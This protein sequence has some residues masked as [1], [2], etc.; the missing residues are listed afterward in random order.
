M[1]QRTPLPKRKKSQ[2]QFDSAAH[3]PT[4]TRNRTK[5]SSSHAGGSVW[6]KKATARTM[7]ANNTKDLQYWKIDFSDLQL[8]S[9]ICHMP[10]GECFR[11]KFRSADVVARVINLQKTTDLIKY[12]ETESASLFTLRHQN[13]V[14]FLGA[15]LDYSMPLYFVTEALPR[16]NLFDLIHNPSVELDPRKVNKMASSIVQGMLYLHSLVPSILHLSLS[17]MNVM[18]EE[19]YN[20]K[21]GEIGFNRFKN[22]E[23]CAQK[24]SMPSWI[25]PE[26]LLSG[27]ASKQSDVYSFGIIF[28]EM[29]TRQIPYPNLTPAQIISGVTMEGIRPEVPTTCP[30]EYSKVF[31]ACWPHNPTHRQ[32]FSEIAIL[33][34]AIPGDADVKEMFLKSTIINRPASNRGD[35]DGS[36]KQTV[37]TVVEARNIQLADVTA[38]FEPMIIVKHGPHEFKTSVMQESSRPVWNESFECENLDPNERLNIFLT[39]ASKSGANV[40]GECTIPTS[41]FVGVQFLDKWYPLLASNARASR[42]AQVRISIKILNEKADEKEDQEDGISAKNVT[43][44]ERL[45]IGSIGEVC[46]AKWKGQFVAVRKLFAKRLSPA[47]LSAVED[48]IFVY[49]QLYHPNLIHIHGASLK[50]GSIFFV[51][52]L[53]EKGNLYSFLRS[54]KKHSEDINYIITTDICNAMVFLHSQSPPIIHQNL[55]SLNV[56]ITK[57]SR[58]KV[59]DFG[60]NSLRSESTPSSLSNLS[61][62]SAPEVLRGVFSTEEKPFSKKSDIY[63][64]AIIV[65]E[66]FTRQEPF[67]VDIT[68]AELVF[69]VVKQ[70][71]RPKTSALPQTFRQFLH[72]AWDADPNMRPCFG[73]ALK[74]IQCE[75][76]D[77]GMDINYEPEIRSDAPTKEGALTVQQ[78]LALIDMKE[79]KLASGT[80]AIGSST[81]A[82]SSPL[83]KVALPSPAFGPSK[84]MEDIQNMP[85]RSPPQGLAPLH[86]VHNP[87][88]HSHH[89]SHHIHG[90]HLQ[91]LASRSAK[92]MDVFQVSDVGD[93]GPSPTPSAESDS[94]SSS[95]ASTKRLLRPSKS[96]PNVSEDAKQTSKAAEKQATLLPPLTS[97]KLDKPRL[98][99]TMTRSSSVL[100]DVSVMGLSPQGDLPRK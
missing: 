45:G 9:S 18:V 71:L 91:P 94:T 87:A 4:L 28:W 83:L 86:P 3:D 78:K 82:V 7:A 21:I 48:E 64:F 47:T 12:F 96:S 43:F 80:S 73:Y 65:A 88:P 62:W 17:S 55:S 33:V 52:D 50:Q 84:S 56:L 16:G 27:R 40:V 31:A 34:Q 54:G 10:Y 19:E 68:A 32:T 89:H 97:P 90:A 36:L 79:S 59:G 60:L 66:I 51:M 24:V 37:I 44:L 46:K 98:D 63:S 42:D 57:H 67:P 49:K 81:V 93:R 58:A 61:F 20:L 95:A 25:S 39:N 76:A 53:A 70:G 100:D 75:M 11:A 35:N 13:V 6:M 26:I 2:G 22:D 41:D 14:L 99:L 30:I 38:V 77:S 5:N 23:R 1:R 74:W 69:R 72:D 85:M 29:I 92:S 15:T 8:G